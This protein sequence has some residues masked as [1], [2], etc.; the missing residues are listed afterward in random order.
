MLGKLRVA[1]LALKPTSRNVNRIPRGEP[2]TISLEALLKS[3]RILEE[4]LLLYCDGGI[5]RNTLKVLAITHQASRLSS[6]D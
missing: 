1:I 5:V 2:A 6:K 3:V 4:L